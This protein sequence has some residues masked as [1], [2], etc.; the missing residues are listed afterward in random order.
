MSRPPSTPPELPGFAFVEPLGSGGFADVF[1]YTQ[2]GLGRQVAVKV[3]LSDIGTDL[4]ASF[5]VEASVMAQLSNHPS[6]V[7]IYQAGVTADG[8]PF[9]VME[10]CPPPHLA[11][12]VRARPL[13]VSKA[14]EVVIQLCGAVE[15]AH[16]LGILH[17]DIKPANILFTEFG[18][19]A[20]T[21]F[22]ISVTTSGAQS[23][24]GVGMSVPWAP[25][26]QLAVGAP[27][28]ATGDVY[29]L[30]ATLWTALVGRSPFH[31]QGGANDPVAM[32]PR[33]RTMALPPTRRPDVPESLE[34]ALRTA[35]A[36]NP[37][38]R[39]DSAL[40]FARTLQSV[41]AELHQPVTTIDV[42][43]EHVIDVREVD[44]AGG[45]RVSGFVS[46]D[47]EHSAA[48][49]PPAAPAATA[50]AA[51]P[52]PAWSLPA[53]VE[54]FVDSTVLSGHTAGPTAPG[55]APA[56]AAP[57][58]AG[59]GPGLASV[60][61]TGSGR[62]TGRTVAAALGATAALAAAVTGFV[63]LGSRAPNATA[64][65]DA[66]TTG[67][68]A[69][70]PIVGTGPAAP[71]SVTVTW[72]ATSLHVTW[73]NPD[74]QPGDSYELFVQADP[75][76]VVFPAGRGITSTSTTAEVATTGERCVTVSVLRA[77]Q[78]SDPVL[79]CDQG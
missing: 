55:L 74:P 46:I 41:Q 3:L 77:D 26:E 6:I 71:A 36:K 79:A 21:D 31:V 54:P 17:R 49:P 25:P 73:A 47:P 44:D 24:Q 29:S 72:S 7:S 14:L 11:L 1:K 42:L 61:P 27:M 75:A 19:A 69:V 65:R 10:Y 23:G 39:F 37:V 33:V 2:L 12:R 9:L 5:E 53:P 8:R 60:P 57:S 20:L 13:T 4:Q 48:P 66:P 70:D 16:R 62:R 50:P 68:S 67:P 43:D 15:T 58:A 52:L 63:L 78:Q 18:R 76:H 45:T 22:G 59:A 38:D 35:M 40:T 30:A 34:R 28:D 51:T 64:E 32:A 56:N